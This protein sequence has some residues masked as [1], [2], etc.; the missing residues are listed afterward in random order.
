MINLALI[1]IGRW[2]KNYLNAAKYIKNCNIKYVCSP[3]I[4]KEKEINS[5]YI[6]I[7]KYKDLLKFPDIDGIIIATSASTHY[8]IADFMIGKNMNLLIEKP[9][10]TNLRDAIE[11]IKNSKKS[12][13]KIMVGHIYNFNPSLVKVKKLINKLGRIKNIKMKSF[14]NGP[15]RTD[16]SDLWD[17]SYHDIY[18]IINLLKKLPNKIYCSYRKSKQITTLNLIYDND[19]KVVIESSSRFRKKERTIDIFGA[20]S[21]IYLNDVTKELRLYSKVGK[22]VYS[23]KIPMNPLVLE[24]KRFLKVINSKNIYRNNLEEALTTIKILDLADKSLEKNI[25]LRFIHEK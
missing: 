22:L 17:R 9:L 23:E 1:G 24:I 8:K 6:K 15:I 10:V 14:S 25:T 4:Y 7:T 20:K 12:N 11:L 3:S 21:R 19:L 13:S 16:V 18:I 5:N 2:G